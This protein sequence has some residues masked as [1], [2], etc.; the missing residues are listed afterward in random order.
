METMSWLRMIHLPLRCSSEFIKAFRISG[1]NY[2]AISLS[3]ARA[4]ARERPPVAAR[5]G[6]GSDSEH[7]A[8]A[9]ALAVVA[10]AY[11]AECE[12]EAQL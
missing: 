9:R 12:R 8:F 4:F 7:L 3:E 11:L 10:E 1:R 5:R 6:D 2:Q